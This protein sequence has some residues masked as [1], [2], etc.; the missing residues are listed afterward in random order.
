MIDRNPRMGVSIG[1]DSN[2]TKGL[3]A[4]AHPILRRIP[5][6]FFP[7]QDLKRATEWY[8]DLLG[9]PIVPREHDDGIYIFDMGG[10]EIILDSNIYGSPSVI[11][12]AADDIE[13]AHAFCASR[14][15]N[16]VTEI[17][18][19]EYISLFHVNSRMVCKAHLVEPKVSGSGRLARMSHVI[20][21]TD[22]PDRTVKWHE[23]LL[24]ARSELYDPFGGLPSI[25]MDPGA[26]LLFDDGRL[27]GSTAVVD[28][29]S[30][31]AVQAKPLAVLGAP[32][33]SAIHTYLRG[34]NVPV[35]GIAE[36]WG[37]RYFTFVDPDG[38]GVIVREAAG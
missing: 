12:F 20:V 28:P 3:V 17:F 2:R 5:A 15:E 4:V 31:T 26:D 38:N 29:D 21:H 1:V 34:K 23:Q 11:M 19:D 13:A 35:S 37:S 18:S 36:N 10:T 22:E 16:E 27:S 30:G 6:V 32:D 8:S 25:A 24:N 14:P 33:L 7:V 9:R